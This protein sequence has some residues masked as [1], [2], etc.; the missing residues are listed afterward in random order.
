M[1]AR[2]PGQA[3]V[4]E[5]LSSLKPAERTDYEARAA[6]K[7]QSLEQYVLRRIQKKT[8]K[9]AAK[10]AEATSAPGLFFTDLGGD[11]DL[12]NAIA[13][14]QPTEKKQSKSS[15][16]SDKLEKAL[17][18]KKAKKSNKKEKKN[19]KKTAKAE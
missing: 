5:K 2:G 1:N 19:S 15:E 10:P 18:D 11:P 3:M 17:K 12:A 6:A 9:N 13:D 14:T 7:G 8:E 16:N 4:A